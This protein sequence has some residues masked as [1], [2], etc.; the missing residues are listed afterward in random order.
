MKKATYKILGL[1]LVLSLSACAS[2][3]DKKLDYRS[4]VKGSP[5]EVPP[6]LSDYDKNSQFNLGDG[7]RSTDVDQN[8]ATQMPA[9]T[10]LVSA[11]DMRIERSGETRW[12]VVNRPAEQ[13]WPVLQSFWED[14][15][16]TI[17]SNQPK[18]GVMETDWAENRASLPQTGLRKLIGGALDMLYDTGYR[19]MF[20]TRIERTSNGTEIYISHRGMEEVYTSSAKD[21][22]AWQPRAADPQL[23]GQLLSALMVRLGTTEEQAKTALQ[24]SVN[25]ARGASIKGDTLLLNDSMDSAWR[26]IGLSLDRVG[27][28]VIDR[29]FSSRLYYV[30]PN[31]DD[32]GLLRKSFGKLGES[33]QVQL[34]QISTNQ[35]EVSF[36]DRNGASMGNDKGLSRVLKELQKTLK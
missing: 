12:L 6:G 14:N 24:S 31:P 15:G 27:L 28:S 26:R 11:K 25:T 19:D 2:S 23:E 21:N 1:A 29:D 3:S 34:K 20:R 13:V 17:R 7:V 4:Q 30:T 18:L 33:Y 10:L 35:V 9:G 32:R 8:A 22:T 5:L 16:F 36:S